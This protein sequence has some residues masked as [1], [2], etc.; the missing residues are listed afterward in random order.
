MGGLELSNASCHLFVNTLCTFAIQTNGTERLR[1]NNVGGFGT[2]LCSFCLT[3]T[4]QTLVTVENGSYG[5]LMLSSCLG[6][7]TY[8]LYNI[9]NNAGTTTANL[10][11]GNNIPTCIV[12]NAVKV[13]S[14]NSATY[15]DMRS[16]YIRFY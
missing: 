2:Q 5:L 10:I 11:Q 8:A 6:G 12:G 7:G 13:A 3:G 14:S 4:Y 1:V 9:F 15:C 16:S